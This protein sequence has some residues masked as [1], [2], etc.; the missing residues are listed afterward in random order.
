MSRVVLITGCSSGIGRAT[1]QSFAATGSTVYATARDVASLEGLGHTVQ[2][3]A[4]DVLDE[5]SMRTVVEEIGELHGA[6]DILVNNAGYGLQAPIETADMVDIR[7]QFETNVFGL[8]RLTQL[9]LPGMRRASRGRIINVSSMAGRFT[10]PGGGFY[11][12]SKHAV[13]AISDALR[14]EVAPFDILVALVEPGPVLTEFGV[15]AV[16]TMR[17]G[18]SDTRVDPS[19]VDPYDDFMH[20]VAATYAGAYDGSRS[21]LASSAADVAEVI[22]KAATARRPRARYVVGPVARALVTAR[23]VLPDRAFDALVRSQFP[24]P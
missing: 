11:H 17:P 9:V 6:V 8:V 4:L 2:A 7:R 16:N 3:R 13:E 12:A 21:S 15:T 5:G 22:L 23:R 14:L 1:V 20:R 10:L 18:D 24:T 19:S